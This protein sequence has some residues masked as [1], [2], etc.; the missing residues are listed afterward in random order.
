MR[1]AATERRA[2][3]SENMLETIVYVSSARKAL[4]D[5]ALE[6][7]LKQARALNE[8]DGLTGVLLYHDGNFVQAL[9][10]ETAPLEETFAR[11]ERDARHGGLITLHRAP[12][13]RRSFPDWSMGFRRSPQR[14]GVTGLFALTREALDEKLGAGVDRGVATLLEVFAAVSVAAKRRAIR[15]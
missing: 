7:L 9:E 13:G 5:E 6:S 4:D 1:R 8:R 2:G 14:E 10:G 15:L 11:I 3:G 12:I